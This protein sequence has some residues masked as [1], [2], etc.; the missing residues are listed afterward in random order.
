MH[1]SIL[2]LWNPPVQIFSIKLFWFRHYCWK[3]LRTTALKMMMTQKTSQL[4]ILRPSFELSV[5][6]I[7][8]DQQSRRSLSLPLKAA[9]AS[10]CQGIIP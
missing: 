8:L 10:E 7:D 6:Q 3:R 2:P 5:Q 1:E 4:V 9:S